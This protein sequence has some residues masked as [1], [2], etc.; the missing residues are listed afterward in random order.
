MTD[1]RDK[2]KG[3]LGSRDQ[4]SLNGTLFGKWNWQ[5]FLN[6]KNFGNKSFRSSMKRKK[7]VRV[8]VKGK[9]DAGFRLWKA[10]KMCNTFSEADI[11][12]VGNDRRLNY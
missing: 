4:S 12:E 5:F 9:V 7:V 1:H 11:L 6:T 10:I 2:I 3:G 8:L